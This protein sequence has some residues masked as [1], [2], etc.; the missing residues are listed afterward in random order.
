[1]SDEELERRQSLSFL[2]A[3]GLKPLP[4]LQTGTAI[5][6]RFRALSY[7]KLIEAVGYR[8]SG[9]GGMYPTQR[10]KD[11]WTLYFERF[12][13]E[14]PRSHSKFAD[15]V[16]AHIKDD[17]KLY[18]IL[19][20]C[21][22]VRLIDSQQYSTISKAMR[23]EL[24]GF[25]FVGSY[26]DTPTL[27]PV[28]DEAEANANQADYAEMQKFPAAAEHFR[29]SIEHIRQ[30]HFRGSVTESIS[31]VESVVKSLTNE[32]SATLGAGLKLLSKQSDLHPALKSGLEKIY[33][34]TNSPNGMRHALSD[35]ATPVSEAE[36]RYMLSACLAFA[37]WLK[38][39]SAD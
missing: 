5:T 12:E 30:G 24:L 1:M 26:H 11:L 21:A 29:Q 27:M 17:A 10:S 37:A 23:G 4:Q 16:K 36:A 28:S 19:Q 34:W 20:F 25:R 35:D 18:D 38:R 3:E 6:P 2:E 9:V 15:I 32:K 8:A 22:R 13:D 14:L 33:G 39:S 7:N 31:G